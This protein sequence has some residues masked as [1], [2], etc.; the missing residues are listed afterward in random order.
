[1][2]TFRSGVNGAAAAPFYR[3]LANCAA[4]R[5]VSI[6]VVTMEGEDCAMEHLGT[7]ADLSG[8]EVEIVDP[9]SLASKVSS[10]VGRRVL[11][12]NGHLKCSA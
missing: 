4:D 2:G 8:G 9:A 7:A 12:T 6:S 11:A 5:G 10:L 1:V 3:E